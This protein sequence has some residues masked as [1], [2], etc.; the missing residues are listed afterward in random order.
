[1]GRETTV[2]FK[3]LTKYVEN[4]NINAVGCSNKK[5]V[6]RDYNIT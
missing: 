5:K 6:S 1:M 3:A 4:C 2:A